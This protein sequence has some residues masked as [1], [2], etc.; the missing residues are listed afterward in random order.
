MKTVC[1]VLLVSAA[2]FADAIVM[3]TGERY[4]GDV[5]EEGDAYRIKNETFPDG[6]V[7]RK[8]A[9]QTR[10]PAPEV[11][12]ERIGRIVDEA[13]AKYD[14]AKWSADP[15]A[16]LKAAAGMLFDPELEATEA[17]EIYPARKDDFRAMV[18]RI[19]ELRKLC[20]D[21]QKL[22]GPAPATPE[23]PEPGKPEG[24][25]PGTPPEKQ[26]PKN[27]PPGEMTAAIETLKTGA[28][29][30]ILALLA[31]YDEGKEER[32]CPPMLERLK[33]EADAQ[34]R[35]VL[36][37]AI[38]KYQGFV[39]VRTVENALKS[40]GVTEEFRK[41]IAEILA[42]RKEEKAITMLSDIA[43][44]AE[45]R[46][47]RQHGRGLLKE[48]GNAC[49]KAVNRYIHHPD[50]RTRTDAVEFV[51]G[52]GTPEAYGLLVQCLILGT[53]QELM[54][55]AS[56][57]VALRDLCTE[58]LVSAGDKA[59]PALVGG[60]SNGNLRKWCCFCL[61][62]ISGEGYAESDVR[63]WTAWWRKRQAENAGR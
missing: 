63:S 17:A 26:A 25:K 27:V 7:V 53:S 46:D 33:T 52:I 30:D 18:K 15:N 21:G 55:A 60:L 47:T 32:F 28:A 16:G 31:R 34:T 4:I 61:Q 39:V 11:L 22:E 5:T 45:S 42:G 8:D 40:K 24:A 23:K 9:V 43:F 58:K 12:L 6:I 3:K 20:R 48:S 29:S 41:V 62:K 51:A 56:I 10:Y 44:G 35:E 50:S 14:D 37:E 1:A 38:G 59:C 57:D 36:R 54:K 2:A 19:Q 13:A 49:L